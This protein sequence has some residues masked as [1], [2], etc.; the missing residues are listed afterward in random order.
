MSSGMTEDDASDR[1]RIRG[2]T[3]YMMNVWPR[4]YVEETKT[5]EGLAPR[6]QPDH[7]SHCSP[8]DRFDHSKNHATFIAYDANVVS[9]GYMTTPHLLKRCTKYRMSR[10]FVVRRATEIQPPK[11]PYPGHRTR[12]HSSKL[13][14][15]PIPNAWVP[16]GER[17]L[18]RTSTSGGK[19]RDIK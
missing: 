13:Q 11:N 12:T 10:Y 15:G 6:C 17:R 5:R 16:F 18:K 1:R 14:R 4:A 19:D 3:S 9:R 2:H 7:L 8:V